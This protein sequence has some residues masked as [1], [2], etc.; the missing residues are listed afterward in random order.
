[1]LK[2]HSLIGRFPKVAFIGGLLL[3]VGSCVA[4]FY[5][6]LAVGVS[7]GPGLITARLMLGGCLVFLSSALYLL[8]RSTTTLLHRI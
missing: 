1:M 4:A 5:S 2:V 6:I 3:F 7:D 8:W